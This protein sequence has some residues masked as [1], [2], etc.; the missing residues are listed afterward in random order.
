MSRCKLI[1]VRQDLLTGSFFYPIAGAIR[2]I[3]AMVGLPP[4]SHEE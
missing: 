3:V 2:K 4:V 1:E